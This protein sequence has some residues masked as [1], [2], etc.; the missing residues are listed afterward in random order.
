MPSLFRFLF[1]TGA[2]AAAAYAGLYM[3]ATRFEPESRSAVYRLHD[4]KTNGPFA[5]PEVAVPASAG[6][7]GAPADDETEAPIAD[8]QP[9]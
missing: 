1:V 8:A 7:T 9:E 2:L 5:P 6:E 3:L 4:L